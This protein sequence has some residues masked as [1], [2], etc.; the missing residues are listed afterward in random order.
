MQELLIFKEAFLARV[1]PIF[2]EMILDAE[3][4]LQPDAYPA[5]A[6]I[7][8]VG[9]LVASVLRYLFGIW[10]RRI[11]AKVSTPEQHARIEKMQAPA[12]HWLPYLLILSPTP[13]GPALIMAAGFFKLQPWV[14]AAAIIAAELLWRASPYL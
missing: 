6:A 13:F 1:L 9:A 8:A 4:T 14:A 2:R 10:L 7:A 3:R 5:H 11:P 12:K